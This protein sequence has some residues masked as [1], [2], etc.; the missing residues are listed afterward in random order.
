LNN[1]LGEIFKITSFGE[2]HG[3]HVGVVIDGCPAGIV[4][5]YEHIQFMLDKRKP[6]QTA[7]STERKEEDKFEIISGIF[8]GMT[9][10]HPITILIK[11]KDQKGK[12]YDTLKE[13]YRP[14]HADFTYENKYKV[15]DYKGGG[16]ASARVTAGWVA[17][18]AIAMQILNAHTD[19]NICAYVSQIYNINIGL[20]P[21]KEELQQRYNTITRCPNKEVSSKMEAAILLA[22]QDGDSLGGIISCV[23]TDIP[24]GLG[25][26]VFSKLNA[27][28]GHAML[29]IN[30]VKGF[31]IGSGFSS[32]LEKGSILNDSFV[33]E[34][35]KIVTRSNNSG[36]IQGGISNG[37]PIE[38]RVA[39]KP[40]AT[41]SSEQKTLNT[42]GE[43][44]NLQ[45]HGRH[46][47]CV[48]PRAVP[49]VEA[50]A[51][52]VLVNHFLYQKIMD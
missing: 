49:I 26:P 36:G 12:D 29:S 28:L 37:M 5:D 17:A 42:A 8:E 11:N 48:V 18:G 43:D 50:M 30:A 46:D 24:V 25:D 6:G 14:S 23:I 45:A 31:E 13:V 34:G 27:T 44:I 52:L 39:F 21:S 41:I 19:I 20:K 47:P 4:L 1:T 9:T 40:T 51:A 32:V 7:I 38:F 35:E 33:K 3:S 22:K 10:G 16:R 2:S 15:R